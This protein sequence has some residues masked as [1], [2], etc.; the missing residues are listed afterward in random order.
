MSYELQHAKIM[1]LRIPTCTHNI[2]AIAAVDSSKHN[3]KHHTPCA[4][5]SFAPSRHKV[6][7]GQQPISLMPCLVQDQ[8]MMHGGYL[9]KMHK[10]G[11]TSLRT[12][13]KRTSLCPHSPRIPVSTHS[14]CLRKTITQPDLSA[15]WA[16][17]ESPDIH[18][19]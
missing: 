6:H 9:S 5:T 13:R 15:E 1:C 4:T 3:L 2:T 14:H 19:S 11:C 10:V 12:S 17:S 8:M 18:S 16:T 7:I